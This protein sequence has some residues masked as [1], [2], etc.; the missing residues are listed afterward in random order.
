M[1]L[2]WFYNSNVEIVKWIRWIKIRISVKS[3]RVLQCQVICSF[4]AQ[5]IYFLINAISHLRQEHCFDF[6]R[7]A[8]VDN[9]IWTQWHGLNARSVQVPCLE[10]ILQLLKF[11]VSHSR[12]GIHSTV[13]QD[14]GKHQAELNQNAYKEKRTRKKQNRS[15][16]FSYYFKI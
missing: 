1:Q 11:L 2:F 8:H 16:K 5:N 6:S 13:I 10:E 12:L 15:A 3:A 9:L 7:Q 4:I 14:I